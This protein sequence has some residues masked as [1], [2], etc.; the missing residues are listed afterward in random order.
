VLRETVDRHRIALSRDLAVAISAAGAVFALS[1]AGGGYGVTTRAYAGIAAW[2]LLGVGA[3]IGLGAVRTRLDRFAFGALTLF[4]A[5]AVWTLVSVAWAPDAGRT[6][7]RFNQVS[8]YVAVLAVAI[9]LGR[10][11][12]A[13]VVVC[14]VALGVAGIAGVSLVSRLFPS[15][16]GAVPGATILPIVQA[17]LSFPLGYWNGLGI[18]VALAYPLLLAI[19]TS[20]RSRVVQALAA[21]PLPILAADM[22][23]TS[24]RGAF[25]AALVALIAYAAITPRRWA[26]LTAIA[27]AAAEGAVSVAVI[28]PR[29]ELSNGDMTNPIAIQQGHQVALVVGITC[30]VGVLV[31]FGVNELGKR[32]PTPPAL[33][34]RVVAGLFVVLAVAAIVASHPVRHFDE[35]KSSSFSACT[36]SGQTCLEQHLLSSSGSGRWQFWGAAVGQFKAHPM[37]GGGAGSWYYW[38]LQH[39]TSIYSQSAHSLYLEALGELGIVGFLFIVG[40]VFVALVGAVRSALALASS[41]AAA[42]AAC[43]IAFFVAAGYDWVWELAGITVVG[44]GMVGVALGA[45][46]IGE[47]KPWRRESVVRPAVALTA[48]GAV[49]AQ[50]I[51]LS[52]NLHLN[53]SYAAYSSSQ[54]ARATSEALAA[55]ALEPWAAAPYLQLGELAEGEGR[56]AVAHDWLRKAI[57]RSPLD[58]N[59]WAA[60]AKV[61]ALRGRIALADREYRQAVKLYPTNPLLT[62]PTS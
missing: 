46:P 20:R 56:Y 27:L 49:L 3:A 45:S 50:F 21:L 17:R 28:K 36:G 29:A 8:L 7:D 13:Y 47:L 41:E 1:Y 60:A 10:T 55:K 26:A 58:S 61:D 22:Y 51:A 4:A 30:A 37:Q 23:F 6:F 14:G 43:A 38:W 44:M 31:W 19:M 35:F 57:D 40:A 24:S 48:V 33:A 15:V 52:A 53:N 34:G 25:V 62:A 2:W 12:S 18:D 9:V 54:A 16:F 42:A 32:V 39:Q 11:V 5:F 59:L